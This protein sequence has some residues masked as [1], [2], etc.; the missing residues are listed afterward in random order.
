MFVYNL[1]YQWPHENLF[2]VKPFPNLNMALDFKKEVEKIN[3]LVMVKSTK[4]LLTDDSGN[5]T[6]E[7]INNNWKYFEYIDLEENH[8]KISLHIHEMD[9]FIESFCAN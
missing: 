6:S 7:E 9:L 1:I 8:H 2:T 3:N 4:W 5:Q